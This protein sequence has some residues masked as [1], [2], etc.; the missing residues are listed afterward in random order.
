[1]WTR[2]RLVLFGLIGL[3]AVVVAVTV[4][5]VAD[6][7]DH[8]EPVPAQKADRPSEGDKLQQTSASTKP[9]TE[10][11]DSVPT[12]DQLVIGEGNDYGKA[13]LQKRGVTVQYLITFGRNRDAIFLANQQLAHTSDPEKAR[14][15]LWEMATAAKA[16][17]ENA[18]GISV[19]HAYLERATDKPKRQRRARTMIA[20]LLE[21]E[22]SIKAYQKLLAST[23]KDEEPGPLFLAMAVR[24]NR[25]D[26]SDEAIAAYQRYL[27]EYPDGQYVARFQLALAKLLETRQPYKALDIYRR[28]A[29]TQDSDAD[30]QRKPSSMKPG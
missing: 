23:P 4:R 2:N 17:D 3:L 19:L 14:R 5:F 29:S 12:L 13:L 8:T 20:E 22:A 9:A 24:L 7:P 6:T 11:A 18:F 30:T 10:P 28:M 21:P 1:M 16:A 15:L 25:L 26:R 27:D